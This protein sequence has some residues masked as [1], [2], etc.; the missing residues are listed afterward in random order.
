MDGV[1]LEGEVSRGT[2]VESV[3]GGVAGFLCKK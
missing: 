1:T 3:K 2:S